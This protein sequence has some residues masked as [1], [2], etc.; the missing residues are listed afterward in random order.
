MRCWNNWN[1]ESVDTMKTKHMNVGQL[2]QYCK[3]RKLF[4]YWGN[5]CW[6]LLLLRIGNDTLLLALTTTGGA[7]ASNIEEVYANLCPVEVG[8]FTSWWITWRGWQGTGLLLSVIEQL[9]IDPVDV[10]NILHGHD[11]PILPNGVTGKSCL[12]DYCTEIFWLSF[13][14]TGP[15]ESQDHYLWFLATALQKENDNPSQAYDSQLSAHTA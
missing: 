11:L 2:D 8:C 14:A 1:Q 15:L 12:V 10:Q 3:R 13:N 7:S 9:N 5:F 4:R 6:P